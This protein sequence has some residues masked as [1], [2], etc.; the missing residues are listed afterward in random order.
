MNRHCASLRERGNVSTLHNS[1]KIAEKIKQSNVG[2][3]EVFN[4]DKIEENVPIL[5]KDKY[6]VLNV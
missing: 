2:A 3:M 4:I 1:L 5:S 6:Q